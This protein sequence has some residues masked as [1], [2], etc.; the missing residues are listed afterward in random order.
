MMEHAKTRG[1]RTKGRLYHR[2]ANGS[3]VNVDTDDD[4]DNEEE[5]KSE[6]IRHDDGS[7]E[8]CVSDLPDAETPE[9]NSIT[10]VHNGE[11]KVVLEPAKNAWV[12]GKRKRPLCHFQPG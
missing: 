3:L 10:T 1:P 5:A 9:P 4:N 11:E 2:R 12:Q 8:T 6:P 7:H